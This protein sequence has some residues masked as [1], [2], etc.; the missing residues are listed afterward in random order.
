MES[1]RMEA[2]LYRPCK[3]HCARHNG[4]RIAMFGKYLLPEFQ[5]PSNIVRVSA[6]EE[7]GVAAHP[8]ML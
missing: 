8:F 1:L 4:G 2:R 7:V 5:N 3:N 6:Y